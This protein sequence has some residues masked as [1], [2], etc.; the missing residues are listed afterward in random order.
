MSR[1][2]NLSSLRKGN[3]LPIAHLDVPGLQERLN[4]IFPLLDSFCREFLTKD[5]DLQAKYQFHDSVKDPK[6]LAPDL[7]IFNRCQEEGRDR[8]IFFHYGPELYRHLG[9]GLIFPEF[10]EL[11]KKTASLYEFLLP[12]FLEAVKCIEE[13]F[14][15]SRFH[16]KARLFPCH[17]LRFL[18]YLDQ[19]GV[20]AKNHTDR[21]CLTFHLGETH[22]G[23]ITNEI[24]QNTRPD[25]VLMFPGRRS[26]LIGEGKIAEPLPHRVEVND[27]PPHERRMSAV[28]FLHV[29]FEDA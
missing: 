17:K 13:E 3:S 25:T 4:N 5:V 6:D 15:L 23:L 14:K 20:T 10:W 21:S 12:Q 16:H 22:P 18:W 26:R 24:P 29:G 2:T 8:K 9:G 27:L 11:L 28:F 19:E 7:G 1:I